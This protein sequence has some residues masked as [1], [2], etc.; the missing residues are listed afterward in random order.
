MAAYLS[1]PPPINMTSGASLQGPQSAGDPSSASPLAGGVGFGRQPMGGV[2]KSQG[3]V[4]VGGLPGLQPLGA[5]LPTSFSVG[6]TGVNGLTLRGI[7]H[8]GGWA[9][10][11]PSS[12]SS[13]PGHSLPTGTL[14][15]MLR[16]YWS[17]HLAPPSHAGLSPPLGMSTVGNLGFWGLSLDAPLPPATSL[18]PQLRHPNPNKDVFPTPCPLPLRGG[19]WRTSSPLVMDHS[20]V[21]TP[22]SVVVPRWP[23]CHW[24]SNQVYGGHTLSSV[25]HLDKG[26][27]GGRSSSSSSAGRLDPAS[28]PS[29][30]FCHGG[31][32]NLP[33]YDSSDW[34]ASLADDLSSFMTFFYP[35]HCP[36]A[37]SAPC[38]SPDPEDPPPLPSPVPILA[39][40]IPLPVDCFTLP[41]F[42][43]GS[44]YLHSHN[45]ILFWLCSPIF[46]TARDDSL[47]IT[48]AYNTLASQFWEGQR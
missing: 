14:S 41:P 21:L 26:Y 20:W 32:I 16:A 1:S 9:G 38:L 15:L 13:F 11:V 45:L 17:L 24:H 43:S 33:D 46:S 35:P 18:P 29:S 30:T 2:P 28:S 4:S 47:L 22:P 8:A 34:G 31:G 6:G 10:L 3:P 48:D 19:S 40:P 36:L 44:N 27:H 7:T 12:A 25:W 37:H 23:P 5:F 39:T 42:N